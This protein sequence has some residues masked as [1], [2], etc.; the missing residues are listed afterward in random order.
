MTLKMPVLLLGVLKGAQYIH[1]FASR[2]AFFDLRIVVAGVTHSLAVNALFPA[3]AA[4]FRALLIMVLVAVPL[5][6][7]VAEITHG[8][9][10]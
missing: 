9:A 2:K 3:P 8:F 1:L 6:V 10:L 4:H 5:A 7:F